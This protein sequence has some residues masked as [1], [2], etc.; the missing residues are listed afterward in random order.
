MRDTYRNLA[1]VLSAVLALWLVLGFWPLS[2]GWQIALSLLITAACAGVLWR[3]WSGR[4]NGHR[5]AAGVADA[6]LPPDDYQGA[7]VLVCGDSSALFEP[8][9]PFRETRQGWFLQVQDVQLLP[10]LLHTLKVMR[11]SLLPQLSLLLA[12]MPERHVSEDGICQSLLGWKRAVT[13]CHLSLPVWAASWISP[14]QAFPAEAPLWFSNTSHSVDL[15][16]HDSDRDGRPLSAWLEESEASGRFTRLSMALWLESLIG[17]QQRIVNAP[18]GGAEPMLTPW[19]EGFCITQVGG[20]AENLWQRHIAEIT[21]LPPVKTD[22]EAL[23]PLPEPLLSMLPRRRTIGWRMRFWRQMGFIVGLFLALAMLGSFINNQRLIHSVGDRLALYHRLPGNPP[24]PK[25]LAQQHLR[26]DARLLDRWLQRGEPLGYGMGLYQGMRLIPPV[27][28]AINDWAPASAALP[29]AKVTEHA[30]ET[31]RLNGMSLFD[32]GQSAL[33]AGSTKMLVNSL[34]G[35]RARPG[36]L[37]V[38]AGHTDNTGNPGLNQA[39]SL[40]RAEAVRNWMRDTGDIPESCFAV[41]GYG[42]TR[43]LVGNDTAK[44]RAQNRRVEISLLPQADACQISGD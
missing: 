34:M 31:V 18:P 30:A 8:G 40:R 4:L 13:Q 43:P 22:G 28:A 29:V 42:D 11:P 16:L 25:T 19:V 2:G 32:S 39:L 6:N 1:A 44:G 21:T 23:L 10:A 36:W 9:S 26:A 3:Q 7:V 38:I 27:E 20:R 15:L 17:W 5:S 12:I 14:P 35:I 41:Q 24:E 33:K 37:I